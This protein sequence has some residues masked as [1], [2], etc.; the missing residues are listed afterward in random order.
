MNYSPTNQSKT[1]LSVRNI[2]TCF[3][4]LACVFCAGLLQAQ[5]TVANLSAS[6][7]YVNTD[8]T[9]LD[10]MPL[11]IL[12]MEQRTITLNVALGNIQNISKIATAIGS[13]EGSNDLFYKEFNL[14]AEGNFSDGTSYH[15]Q[16]NTVTI[17]VG[18]YSGALAYYAEVFAIKTDGTR[19]EGR[20]VEI[21]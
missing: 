4:F 16:G 11:T 15:A 21:Q 20:R 2:M 14:G 18:N 10:T 17:S 3:T 7:Q 1:L 13:S 19:T 12:R 9:A 6:T 8:Q 5:T